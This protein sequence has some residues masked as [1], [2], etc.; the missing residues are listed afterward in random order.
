[1]KPVLAI[2]AIGGMNKPVHAI[3]DDE[4]AFASVLDWL[5]VDRDASGLDENGVAFIKT[6]SI[7]DLAKKRADGTLESFEEDIAQR[8]GACVQEMSYCF[9]E[10]MLER[11]Y[12][13][14]IS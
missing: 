8:L 6:H 10:D 11:F 12:V 1:M 14:I 5:G 9:M 13:Q 7:V 2:V 3:T 4:S